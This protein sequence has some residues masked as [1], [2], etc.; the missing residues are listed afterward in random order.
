MDS[1]EDGRRFL[2]GSDWD[3][4][5]RGMTD[6][7]AGVPVPPPQKPYPEDAQL[8]DLVAPEDLTVGQMSVIQ[9]IKQRRSHRSFTKESLTLEEL[10]FLVWATQGIG[11][12]DAT[13][14]RSSARCAPRPAPG[15]A[16]PLRPTCWCAA[17]RAWQRACTATCPWNTRSTWCA[18]T[19]T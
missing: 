14:G 4:M 3:T 6:Q 15:R 13:R 18:T 10:S 12:A 9:A 8:I 19:R 2:K 16:I 5:T 11:Q 17:W 7:R 1:L